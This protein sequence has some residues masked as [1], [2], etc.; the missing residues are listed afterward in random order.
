MVE[1][2]I[3]SELLSDQQCRENPIQFNKSTDKHILIWKCERRKRSNI[4]TESM[5]LFEP[6]S[7]PGTKVSYIHKSVPFIISALS[8][9]EVSNI[10]RRKKKKYTDLG[11]P[12][13]VFSSAS[14]SNCSRN[15]ATYCK[16]TIL[17]E[18]HNTSTHRE[19]TGASIDTTTKV[20]VSSEISTNL[21]VQALPD[22]V[23]EEQC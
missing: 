6:A 8:D 23:A 2:A 22:F 16:N 17:H 4:F 5:K 13:G 15:V 3:E 19:I 12:S 10:C 11:N 7:K 21:H 1:I 14:C 9:I 20:R 18:Y